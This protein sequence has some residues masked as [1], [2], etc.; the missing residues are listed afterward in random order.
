MKLKC[1]KNYT[2]EVSGFVNKKKL[3]RSEPALTVNTMYHGELVALTNNIS[4]G[5]ATVIKS[6]DYAFMCFNDERKWETYE[7]SLFEPLKD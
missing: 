2:T 3:I 5:N 4:F 1:I 7:L 6:S